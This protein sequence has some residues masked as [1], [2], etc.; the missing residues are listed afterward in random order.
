M[1]KLQE[2]RQGE[3][4]GHKASLPWMPGVREGETPEVIQ[5]A[6]WFPL[7][8]APLDRRAH[9]GHNRRKVRPLRRPMHRG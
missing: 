8:V 4:Y 7:S 9:L 2:A 3:F 6:V 5:P 1:C